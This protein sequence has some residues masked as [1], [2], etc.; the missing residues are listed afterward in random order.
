MEPYKEIT[1]KGVYGTRRIWIDGKELLPKKSQKLINHSPDGFNWGYAGS[2]PAQLALA[3]LLK[4]SGDK[5]IAL[6]N[7]QPF[8]QIV[9]ARLPCRDFEEK[10]DVSAYV[11]PGTL[12]L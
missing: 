11:L 4:V 8:K 12:K 3:I 5:K 2:G 7:Y 1:L 10:I 9:I 6:S